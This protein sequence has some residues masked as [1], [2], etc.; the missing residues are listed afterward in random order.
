[1]L[2][3]STNGDAPDTCNSILKFKNNATIN[4][5]A[6]YFAPYT[7]EW[8]I[9]FEDAFF[10]ANENNIKVMGPRRTFDKNNFFIKPKII[11]EYDI[12]RNID[13]QTSLNK[14]ISFFM[15]HVVKDKK[16]SN[17]DAKTSLET[18]QL[19]LE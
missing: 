5:L 8:S 4:I 19:I 11:E 9:I 12:K 1:M 14:S 17:L 13:Y 3:F 7:Y 15:E 2:N 10:Y 6:S 16:F 18:N